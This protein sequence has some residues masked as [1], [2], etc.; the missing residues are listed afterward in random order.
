MF[1][2]AR[3]E[4]EPIPARVGWGPD[5]REHGWEDRHD[6]LL[7]F[8]S[9]RE[10]IHEAVCLSFGRRTRKDLGKNSVQDRGREREGEKFRPRNDD[11]FPIP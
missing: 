4:G 7:I 3:R 5:S 8:I 1:L 9:D 10:K 11:S 2:L 6:R